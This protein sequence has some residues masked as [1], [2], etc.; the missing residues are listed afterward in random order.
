MNNNNLSS[1]IADIQAYAE[2]NT[3]EDKR[4][5]A[6]ITNLASCVVMLDTRLAKL[7]GIQSDEK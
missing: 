4:L 2:L 6:A 3:S 7:E 1:L 5:L